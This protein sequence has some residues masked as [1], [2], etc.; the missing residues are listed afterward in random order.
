MRCRNRAPVE[1]A[2]KCVTGSCPLPA[3]CSHSALL[4]GNSEL[5]LPQADAH[6]GG[7]YFA[8]G[9]YP[10]RAVGPSAPARSRFK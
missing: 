3:K 5:A 1:I 2:L 10:A 8:F 6:V 7:Y 4:A 9:R